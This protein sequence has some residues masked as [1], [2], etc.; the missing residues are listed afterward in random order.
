V[1]A[2]AE[3]APHTLTAVQRNWIIM[4]IVIVVLVFAGIVIAATKLWL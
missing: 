4:Q 3:R 1:R 2:L